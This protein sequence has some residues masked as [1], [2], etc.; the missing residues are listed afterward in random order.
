LDLKELFAS[1]GRQRILE[2]LAQYREIA[3]MQLVHKTGGKYSEVNRNLK[4]LEAEG[5]IISE[6]RR[7][8]KRAKVRIIKLNRENPR[9][10]KLLKAL[11]I[12]QE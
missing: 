1:K 2:I 12:L 3:V 11:K 7:Q 10:E 5:I 9:T 4:I 6:Y 8:A